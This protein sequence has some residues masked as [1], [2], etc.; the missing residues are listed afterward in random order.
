[1]DERFFASTM[2]T[3]FH[4]KKSERMKAKRCRENRERERERERSVVGRD[5]RLA[6]APPIVVP[7]V[8][9]WPAMRG[10]VS[11]V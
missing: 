9:V 10:V 5:C 8:V 4:I 11:W 1:M 2:D 6:V 7:L 3:I